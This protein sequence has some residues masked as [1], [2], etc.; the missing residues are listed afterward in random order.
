MLLL[1]IVLSFYGN[2]V[3]YSEDSAYHQVQLDA[4]NNVMLPSL[5]WINAIALP[6][7]LRRVRVYRRVTLAEV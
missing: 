2:D 7:H 6:H 5:S 1:S 3:M 4:I